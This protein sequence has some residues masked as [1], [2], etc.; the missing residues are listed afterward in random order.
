MQDFLGQLPSCNEGVSA[1]AG[2]SDDRARRK[3]TNNLN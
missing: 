2:P 1:S 3:C